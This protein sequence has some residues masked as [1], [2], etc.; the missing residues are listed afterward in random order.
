[1]PNKSVILNLRNRH[2]CNNLNR[3]TA[4]TKLPQLLS[5]ETVYYAGITLT[6]LSNKLYKLSDTI[7]QFYH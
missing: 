5:L 1:M 2:Q 7:S 4:N 6:K 3:N